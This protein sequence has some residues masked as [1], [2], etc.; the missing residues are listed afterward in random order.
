MSAIYGQ[1]NASD[2]L[3]DTSREWVR[4][5]MRGAREYAFPRLRKLGEAEVD[6]SWPP[7]SRG[8]II[9]AIGDIQDHQ[10]PGFPKHSLLWVLRSSRA[11]VVCENGPREPQPVGTIIAFDCHQTH[12]LEF[13]NN[14]MARARLWC[15]WN[16]DSEEPWTAES[17]RAAISAALS[18]PAPAEPEQVTG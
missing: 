9:S 11:V 12:G 2:L 17:A 10:D 7:G 4:Y 5:T 1:W 14:P 18:H 15:A 8:P 16:M 13:L 6:L 3:C